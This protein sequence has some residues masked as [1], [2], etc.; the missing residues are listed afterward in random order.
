MDIEKVSKST[1]NSSLIRKVE[2]VQKLRKKLENVQ[3][4]RAEAFCLNFS[5]RK[6]QNGLCVGQLIKLMYEKSLQNGVKPSDFGLVHRICG[7][8]VV[9]YMLIRVT[10]FYKKFK[11]RTGNVIFSFLRT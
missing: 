5:I 11:S 3:S 10:L 4:F 7:P 6:F 9:L 8:K 2:E 1:G